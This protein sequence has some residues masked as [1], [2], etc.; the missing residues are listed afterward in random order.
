MSSIV[1]QM[2]YSSNARCTL[3]MRVPEL[4]HQAKVNVIPDLLSGVI[5]ITITCT[6]IQTIG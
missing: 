6:D 2:I 5:E 4:L 1:K 3:F